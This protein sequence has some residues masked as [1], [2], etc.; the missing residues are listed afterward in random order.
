MQMNNRQTTCLT[1]AAK[2][3]I[4][5]KLASGIVSFSLAD[6]TTTTGLS[7]IAAKNQLLRLK[8]MVTRVSPRQQYFLIIQPEHRNIGAPPVEWWLDDYFT[9]LGH[10]Y[11]LALQS[12][13]GAFG[14]N[15]QAIQETQ[16]ITDIPRRDM[17]IGRIRVRFFVKTD[18]SRTFTQQ[19]PGM[20]A[21]LTVSTP[22][23]TLFDLIRYTSVIGGIER[24]AE[25]IAPLLKLTKAKGLILV[26]N[27]ENEIATAQRLGFVLQA[28][29]ATDLT[30]V[31]KKWL[32]KTIQ[33]VP[34]STHLA[35]DSSAPINR[36]W[37]VINNSRSFL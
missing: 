34:I 25:T 31:V 13:A 6:L 4:D 20:Y 33:M 27:A 22:E 14:S 17:I 32:P 5:A 2:G 8:N 36:E 28:L 1:G 16:I 3:F 7:V 21:P 12:A 30:Q 11:Y 35:I 23:S 37:G 18:I 29:S 26:L 24:A 19:L 10:P 9:W 15:P